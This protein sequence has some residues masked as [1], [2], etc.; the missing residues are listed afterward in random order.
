M[1]NNVFFHACFKE[2]C[3]ILPTNISEFKPKT[4]GGGKS[5]SPHFLSGFSKNLF[6]KDSVEP[7]FF[8]TFN[9]IKSDIFPENFLEIPQ[10]VQ[11]M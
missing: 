3:C 6:S 11:I 1:L 10:V 8:L 5:I 9:I 7:L 4:A 2:K